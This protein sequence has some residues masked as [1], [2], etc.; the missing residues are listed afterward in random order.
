MTKEQQKEE[1]NDTEN[2]ILHA[3]ERE[4]MAK[5]FAGARTTSIAEAAGVTHAML[6]YYFRTKD[7]L[8]DRIISEKVAMLKEVLFQSVA[9]ADDSLEDMIKNIIE[10]H[11]DFIAA[12]PDLPRFVVGE[13]TGASS[14]SKIILDNIRMYAPIM[15]SNLQQKIDMAADRGECR[16]VDA[17]MLM[18]DI[19]SLNIFSYLVAPIANAALNNIMADSSGFLSRRKKENFDTIMRKLR[20]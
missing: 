20:P 18:L 19:A 12:N 10:R 3:A 7:K 8:F 4:F 17:W 13:L 11:L 1:C 2:K 16:R 5:G 6:H 15:I 9:D 14:R